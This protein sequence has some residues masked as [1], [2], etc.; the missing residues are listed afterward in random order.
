MWACDHVVMCPCSHVHMFKVGLTGGIGSGKSVVSRMFGV[1]GVPVYNAD[2][3]ARA[4]ME[5]DE[6]LQARIAQRF[7]H[8]LYQ[9]GKLARSRLASLVFSDDRA[10]NDLNALVH[11]AVRADFDRWAE[12]QASPYVMMEAALMAENEG[13]KRFDQVVTVSCAEPERI[14]RVV[15]RDR[16]N[17]DEVRARMRHQASEAQRLAIAQHAIRNEGNELVIPQVL[18]IHAELLEA[19]T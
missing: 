3:R 15:E 11:P 14:R 16:T 5:S 9:G 12:T 13:W 4:L 6:G 10:L 1:L 7:G 18:R 17:A 2:A 8:D 19:A